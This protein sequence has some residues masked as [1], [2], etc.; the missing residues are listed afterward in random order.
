M[1]SVAE[2]CLHKLNMKL[3][4]NCLCTLLNWQ[5]LQTDS[6]FHVALLL[7]L[8]LYVLFKVE[9]EMSTANVDTS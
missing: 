8:W 3:K 2:D 5:K 6:W 7:K 4:N 9:K 1:C